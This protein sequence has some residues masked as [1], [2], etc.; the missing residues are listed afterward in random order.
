MEEK[1]FVPIRVSTLR[2]DLQISFNA[3]VRVAGKH[4]LYCRQGDSFEGTRLKRLKDKKLKKLFIQADQEPKYREYMTQN[5]EMAY[6][7]TSNRPI[8]TRA[9]VIQGAQQAAAEDAM[10]HPDS[11]AFY[12]AAKHGSKRYIDFILKEKEALKAVLDIENTDHSLSHHG[13]TVSTIA[14]GIADRLG[15]TEMYP[16]S[17]LALGC[18]LHDIE[19]YHSGL[20]VARSLSDFPEGEL[21]IYRKHPLAGV[22]RLKNCDFY[23]QSV[24]SIIKQHE[25][26][27]DGSGFP[28][29]L[30]ENE[31]DPLALLA[32]TANSYDRLVSFE[33]NPPKEA[34]KKLLID[35]LGLHPLTHLQALQD[36]LKERGVL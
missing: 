14:I 26:F 12:Q 21:D 34:L 31:I 18:L 36:V 22:Q 25:E 35:K 16:L 11:Q 29:G 3:Y 2:G 27:I 4:I 23:D 28:L 13:V 10:D 32:S 9:E 20:N 6:S 30:K 24:Y 33:K 8:E 7:K 19:L 1:E 17:H 5:I 15:M